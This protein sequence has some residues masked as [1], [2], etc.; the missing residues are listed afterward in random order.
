M[1]ELHLGKRRKANYPGKC[2][3]MGG[4]VTCRAGERFSEAFVGTVIEF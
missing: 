2:G 4:H 3:A 1:A